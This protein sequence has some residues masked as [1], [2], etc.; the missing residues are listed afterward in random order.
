MAVT[1]EYWVVMS[2]TSYMRIWSDHRTMVGK[3]WGMTGNAFDT[4][5]FI[6]N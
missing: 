3:I 4:T 6:E 5:R 1:I 2:M